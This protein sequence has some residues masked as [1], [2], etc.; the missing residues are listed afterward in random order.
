MTFTKRRVAVVLVAVATVSFAAAGWAVDDQRFVYPVLL[1]T[2][3]TVLY[4]VFVANRNVGTVGRR[5]ERRVQAE[6]KARRRAATA[7]SKKQAPVA[8]AR[9]GPPQV[10]RDAIRQEGRKALDRELKVA[11]ETFAS[12][13]PKATYSVGFSPAK[14][15]GSAH[16]RGRLHLERIAMRNR[17]LAARDAIAAAATC[18][19]FSGAE[20]LGLARA[21]RAGIV[22]ASADEALKRLHV[23]STLSFARVLVDQGLL[24]SDHDDAVAVFELVLSVFGTEAFPAQ[25]RCLFMESVHA[26][27]DRTRYLEL[28]EVFGFHDAEPLQFALHECNHLLGGTASEQQFGGWLD[29]LRGEYQSAGFSPLALDGNAGADLLGRLVVDAAPVMDG[30][31]VTVLMPTF[32][33]SEWIGTAVRSILGQSWQPLE[34]IIVDDGSDEIHASRIRELL[35]DL[36]DP[37]VTLL[38]QERSQGPYVARNRGL[39]QAIGEFVTVHDDDDWSHPQKLETQVQHLLENPGVIANT[40]YGTRIDENLQFLRINDNPWL[41]Q[42]NYSSLMIRRDALESLG[43]WQA[44]RK[45]ADAELHDRIRA[46]WGRTVEGVDSPPL[47]FFRARHGS[48]THGE[49]LKGALDPGRHTYGLLFSSWHA[50]IRDDISVDSHVSGSIP[51][52][53]PWSMDPTNDPATERRFGCVLVGDLRFLTAEVVRSIRA[54]VPNLEG[55][56]GFAIA[57]LDSPVLGRENHL[58]DVVEAITD[59]QIPVLAVN[60]TVGAD[61]VVVLDPTVLQFADNLVSRFT[62]GRVTV[63]L[64]ELP[65]TD[66]LRY[67]YDLTSVLTNAENLFGTVVAAAPTS[68]R[69]RQGLLDLYP[70]VELD[71]LNWPLPDGSSLAALRG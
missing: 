54:S 1:L 64:D 49:M 15:Y 21:R 45:S 13:A 41:N 65:I 4:A 55:S 33:G 23:P 38:H 51:H 22:A 39:A 31:I 24:P 57:H 56:A 6:A 8:V 29:V 47:S 43:G 18:L 58:G 20:L 69:I 5:I 32:N 66:G 67:E 26:S 53:V 48:L 11:A 61:R 70:G 59:L 71:P 9:A 25:D 2:Q 44:V 30:P 7:A 14:F 17:S 50:R 42:K 19:E 62:T 35:S 34:L 36:A 10:D 27:G 16:V 3:A 40:S 60:E 37:R 28:D 68:D 63:V 52:P 46:V 12:Q